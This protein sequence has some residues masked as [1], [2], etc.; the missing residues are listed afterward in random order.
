MVSV[1][2]KSPLDR[3]IGLAL[4]PLQPYPYPLMKRKSKG[5]KEW[6]NTYRTVT[7]P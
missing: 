2:L 6:K 1:I 7:T 3:A 5:K 4:I